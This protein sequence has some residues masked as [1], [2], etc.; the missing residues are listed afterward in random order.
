MT[1]AAL[2]S[3]AELR[4][5][6]EARLKSRHAQERRF[7]LYGRTAIFVALAFLAILLGRIISQGYTT[8]IDYSVTLPVYVDPAR[9]Q[10]TDIGGEIGRAHV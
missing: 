7:R 8:F 5:A 6:V 9:V 4:L 1:D 3:P 2:R 10:R